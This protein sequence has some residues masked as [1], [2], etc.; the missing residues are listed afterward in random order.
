MTSFTLIITDSLGLDIACLIF[1]SKRGNRVF[2]RDSECIRR[3]LQA[4]QIEMVLH[5][6]CESAKVTPSRRSN[7]A[8]NSLAYGVSIVVTMQFAP[9]AQGA[10]IFIRALYAK[11]L[12]SDK[13]MLT[14]LHSARQM[15]C[16]DRFRAAN[17]GVTVNILYARHLRGSKTP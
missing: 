12:E 1:P 14:A 7:K 6:S 8:K 4:N 17:I 15:L 3:L 10:L 2:R 16:H 11:S 13:D 5:N 9:T